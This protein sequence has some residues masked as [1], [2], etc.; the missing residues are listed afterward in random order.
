M[1]EPI[2]SF[3]R[4]EGKSFVT[5]QDRKSGPPSFDVNETGKGKILRK[6]LWCKEHQ[7]EELFDE[8]HHPFNKLSENLLGEALWIEMCTK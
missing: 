3:G 1:K 2:A 8:L 5:E 4:A 7:T 6:T